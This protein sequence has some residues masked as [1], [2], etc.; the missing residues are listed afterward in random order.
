MAPE[1]PFKA[2]D[3]VVSAEVPNHDTDPE[4]YDIVQQ[5][6]IHPPTHLIVLYSRCNK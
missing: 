5:F 3:R 1:V 4:L 6:Q 2:I